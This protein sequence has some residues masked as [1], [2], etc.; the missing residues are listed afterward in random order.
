MKR[1]TAIVM[2]A[3]ITALSGFFAVQALQETSARAAV[4]MDVDSN[5]ILYSKNMDEKLA[6][7]STTKIMTTLV[8]IES[9]RLD[10]KVKISKRASYMEGSSI[11]LREGEVHTVND[12]LYAIMLRSGNDAATAVA[13]HIGGS[14]EGFA[15][16]MNKKAREIGASNTRF[17]NPHG[18]D[19]DGHYTTARDLALITCYA[20]KNPMFS[21]IVS[22]KKKVMEGPPNENWDRVMINKNKMLWQF[23]GGDGVKTGYTNRAG[24]CLVSSAT[25]DGMRLVCVVLNCGPMWND[26][27][28]LLEYGFN[29]YI[30]KR[31][32]EK[33]SIFK[34]VEVRNGKERFVGVKPAEDFDMAL[35][36]DE[37]E[38][39]RLEARGLKAAQAPLKKGDHAGKLEIYIDNNL[40]K[41]ISLE[42]SEGV[43]SSS[44][45]FYL[46]RILRD[47]I[48]DAD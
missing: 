29:N 30:K 7:A 13:E 35:R 28:A 38:N 43:E 8:A 11:Y 16:M 32:V 33:D 31:I 24:R 41:T 47:Y 9:G 18:L 36:A 21:K 6:M 40:L 42:Y 4:V 3:V 22:S 27:S 44:P 5:R 25:R 26:S 17:A 20:L 10:E 37:I 39:V 23:A 34:V 1:N 45:F 14:V 19:A 48:S 2:A 12:L 46:K 15:E